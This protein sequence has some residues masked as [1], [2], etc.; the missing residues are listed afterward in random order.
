MKVE[1]HWIRVSHIITGT[2]CH[3]KI[4][5]NLLKPLL[6]LTLQIFVFI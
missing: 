4:Y 5:R 2:K 6:L 1:N 3:C